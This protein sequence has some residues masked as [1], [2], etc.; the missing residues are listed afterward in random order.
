M[1]I[2]RYWHKVEPVTAVILNLLP[3]NSCS[4]K[5]LELVIDESVR[6]CDVGTQRWSGMFD[7]AEVI[8]KKNHH[9]P[10]E[11][12]SGIFLICSPIRRHPCF[13]EVPDCTIS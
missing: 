2:Y 11:P 9:I 5:A 1:N 7:I 6:I 8:G 4:K 12:V 10:H 3:T 13:S